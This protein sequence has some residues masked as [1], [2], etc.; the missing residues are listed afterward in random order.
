MNVLNGFQ[1]SFTGGELSPDL[2]MRIDLAKYGTACK[3]IENMQIMP[4]GGVYKRTGFRYLH[5]FSSKVRLMPFVFSSTQTYVLC[6][7]DNI[8]TFMTQSGPVLNSGGDVYT[9]STPYSYTEASEMGFIQSADVIYLASRSKTPYKLSRIGHASWTLNPISF[10]PT[11]L[12]PSDLSGYL[13]DNRTAAEIE[14]DGP[15]DHA[16]RFRVTNVD[17]EG[18]ESL[19]SGIVTVMGPENLR[20]NCFPKLN[21]SNTSG[22]TEY[23]VYQE[24]NGKYGYIGSTD[25]S[26]FDAKNIA[27][28]LLD[29]FP[30]AR[31]PFENGNFPGAVCFYQ[32][33]LVFAG[34]TAK[35]Q[36]LWFS[37]TGNY[38]NFAISSP[39]KADDAIDVTISSNEVSLIQWL[40][41]LRTLL[42]GT[43]GVE[44]EIRG[45]GEGGSISATGISILPQSYR[46]SSH[47]G[48]QIVGN[49]VLHV[50]R[51][52]KEVRD[53]LYDF[54]SDS[55]TGSDRAILATHLFENNT[56]TRWTYQQEPDSI[57]WCIRDDGVLL[58]MT[59]MKDHDVYG[60]HR[61]STNGLFIDIACIPGD[62]IDSL[63]VLA[64]RTIDGITSYF[65]EIQDKRVINEADS[66]NDFFVDCGLSYAGTDV[67]KVT[68]LDHLKGETVNILADGGVVKPQVVRLL[69][70][71]GYGVLLDVAASVIHVGLPYE[72]RLQSL[73][74][75]PQTQEG[76]SVGR[77]KQVFSIGVF[78]RATNAVSIGEDF[79][80]MREQ[81][82]R[83]SNDKP[84]SPPA[85]VTKEVF[86]LIGGDVSTQVHVCVSSKDP[87]ALIV[88]AF[89]PTFA[90]Y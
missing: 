61:H 70:G 39:L 36:S 13:Y 56:I 34:S 40:V 47:L 20:N 29:S 82:L 72:A 43:A 83:S 32:Q 16:W 38:E 22:S 45:S 9:I 12:I 50:S 23:R 75:E 52:H 51:T 37:R 25:V 49:T 87:L 1:S 6:W 3:T 46:G 5:Q 90:V 21:W 63:F 88:L 4:H 81:K 26:E 2:T 86:M 33:R 57:V 28:D 71:G 60:W 55:Y 42:V 31:N 8:L 27:P 53:L 58:G 84:N 7:G 78:L 44:W 69:S 54:G 15:N 19:P 76:S 48:A 17:S 89:T 79:E 67:T 74:L 11:A 80:N 64:E 41:S 35:P 73:G 10:S 85:P 65:C 18:E 68:G 66:I 24:K 62:N 77:Q 59:Y 14:A 30:V